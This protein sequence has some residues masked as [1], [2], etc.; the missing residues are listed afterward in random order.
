M[1]CKNVFGKKKI[2]KRKTPKPMKGGRIFTNGLVGGLV[3]GGKGG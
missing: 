1:K 2:K 3:G